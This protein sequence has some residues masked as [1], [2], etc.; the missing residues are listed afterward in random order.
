MFTDNISDIFRLLESENNFFNEINDFLTLVKEIRIQALKKANANVQFIIFLNELIF[1]FE[2]LYAILQLS[3]ILAIARHYLNKEI[4]DTD[5]IEIIKQLHSELILNKQIDLLLASIG[6]VANNS[7]YFGGQLAHFAS[8]ISLIEQS[9]LTDE[10]KKNIA[11]AKTIEYYFKASIGKPALRLAKYTDFVKHIPTELSK[12]NSES[13]QAKQAEVIKAEVV[14]GTSMTAD[15]INSNRKLQRI[16][17]MRRMV[18]FVDT[19]GSL[20]SVAK[21][22]Q[23]EEQPHQN[24]ILSQMKKLKEQYIK[25]EEQAVIIIANVLLL[26]DTYTASATK[27]YLKELRTNIYEI[28][29][30]LQS[31]GLNACSDIIMITIQKIKA[32]KKAADDPIVGCLERLLPDN[33]LDKD[34]IKCDKE[35]QFV[36]RLTSF[37]DARD[38]IHTR[39]FD[40]IFKSLDKFRAIR[41]GFDVSIT[42]LEKDIFDKIYKTLN[43]M[44][45]ELGKHSMEVDNLWVEIIEVF[46]SH[47]HIAGEFPLYFYHGKFGDMLREVAKYLDSIKP[48]A[49]RHA[50]EIMTRPEG[51]NY[52]DS[53]KTDEN[54]VHVIDEKNRTP[55]RLCFNIQRIMDFYCNTGLGKLVAED[56]KDQ[57]LNLEAQ[58]WIDK[59]K[60]LDSKIT[61][62]YLANKHE[63]KENYPKIM[64]LMFKE[65]QET[66]DSINNSF[67]YGKLSRFFGRGSRFA[68]SLKILLELF[69]GNNINGYYDEYLHLPHGVINSTANL[70]DEMVEAYINKHIIQRSCKPFLERVDNFAPSLFSFKPKALDTE[71]I[72]SKST[73]NKFNRLYSKQH[74]LPE[75]KQP[76]AGKGNNFIGDLTKVVQKQLATD[77]KTRSYFLVGKYKAVVNS[78]KD[79]LESVLPPPPSCTK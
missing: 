21:R 35:F 39:I 71:V 50:L 55:A 13:N 78:T 70:A 63:E 33:Y 61:Q 19:T 37:S 11:L 43:S 28:Y 4:K 59:I 34:Y 69:K 32:D 3:P 17:S 36:G 41:S 66:I 44:C 9:Q 72:H 75:D 23:V 58:G 42:Q 14:N 51:Y 31:S 25:D 18:T 60:L 74:L 46:Q 7:G 79:Y 73:L 2:Q 5:K 8:D 24:N 20:K 26:T 56:I 29:F 53:Y 65:I 6:Y 38:S 1:A 16:A 54:I 10:S 77:A 22:H 68:G 27:Q 15:S 49:Y 12:I 47:T 48:Q 67:I 62:I 76:A 40:N 30:R 64:E 57:K 52:T 45:K